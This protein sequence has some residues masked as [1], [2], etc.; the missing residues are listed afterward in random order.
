MFKKDISQRRFSHAVVIETE[1][2]K[3]FH[4]SGQIGEGNDLESRKQFPLLP[5]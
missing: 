1:T 5:N 2:T 3:T 4:I